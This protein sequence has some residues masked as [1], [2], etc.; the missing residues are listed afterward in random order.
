M[1][2]SKCKIC[3]EEVKNGNHFWRTHKKSEADY[4]TE[5]FPRF[6]KTGKRIPYKNKEQYLESEFVDRNDLRN[7]VKNN[8]DSV[9]GYIESFINKRVEEG[10]NKF[11]PSQVESKTIFIPSVSF[12]HSKVIDYNILAEKLGLKKR[13]DYNIV[14]LDLVKSLKKHTLITDTREQLELDSKVKKEKKALKYGDYSCTRNPF[15]FNIE[16]K[17]LTDLIST[18]SGGYERF[19]REIDRAVEAKAYL[20]I[21]CEASFADLAGF[22]YGRKFRA[23]VKFGPDFIFHRIRELMQK[24]ENIQF[25]FSGD[26]EKSSTLI[27]TLYRCKND[28]RKIDWQYL[29]DSKIF[30]LN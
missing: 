24:Y 30:N 21:I 11:L 23:K 10:K 12:I 29:I 5:Y 28:P 1:D 27:E 19:C 3:G 2:I 22:Q 18:I 9:Y 20:F 6:S 13:F 14:D 25:I 26:R 8:H 15:N 7:W 17:S 4:Y 16:R